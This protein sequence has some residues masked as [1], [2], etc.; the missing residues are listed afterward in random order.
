M[1]DEMMNLCALVKKTPDAEGRSR[2]SPPTI[3]FISIIITC[4]GQL[5]DVLAHNVFG[6]PTRTRHRS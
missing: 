4:V 2:P 1:T 3:Y 6:R 5:A